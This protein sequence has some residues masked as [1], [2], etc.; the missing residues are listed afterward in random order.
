MGSADKGGDLLVQEN[1]RMK[2]IVEAKGRWNDERV[3]R[4]LNR[5]KDRI[6]DRMHI[7]SKTLSFVP[8]EKLTLRPLYYKGTLVDYL[9]S[10]SPDAGRAMWHPKT[11]FA[12]ALN[13]PICM[14][15]RDKGILIADHEISHIATVIKYKD[16]S[17]GNNFPA[18][19]RM[20]RR[21]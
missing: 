20:C 16:W 13:I 1:F 14:E 9:C 8:P 5:L 19:Y 12:I 3:F 2:T 17:E 4:L 15:R 7:L 11:G 21:L 10:S 6:E 18:V